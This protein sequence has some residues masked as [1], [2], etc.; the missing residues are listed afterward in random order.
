MSCK[1]GNHSEED[2]DLCQAEEDAYARGFESGRAEERTAAATLR[3]QLEVA[4]AALEAA[5][6]KA[7]WQAVTNAELNML[8]EELRA[9]RMAQRSNLAAARGAAD[10]ADG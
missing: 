1:H 2:C 9:A 7:Q 8:H 5:V 4:Q 10:G 6:S 3:A